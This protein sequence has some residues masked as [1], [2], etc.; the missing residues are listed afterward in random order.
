MKAYLIT[1]DRSATTSLA[2]ELIRLGVDTETW[3]LSDR[4]YALDNPPP[5]GVFV[6]RAAPSGTLERSERERLRDLV[7]WLEGHR[8]M[9]TR[10]IN[11]SGVVAL[12]SGRVL[13]HTALRAAGIPVPRT[14]A[15]VADAEAV[16]RAAEEIGGPVVVMSARPGTAAVRFENARALERGLP[17]GEILLDGGT[18]LVREALGPAEVTRL[19]FVGGTLRR[20]WRWRAEEGAGEIGAPAVAEELNVADVPDDPLIDRYLVFLH[21]HGFG[22]GA[23]EF[24]TTAQ[25]RRLTLGVSGGAEPW[26]W[27]GLEPA[28]A[29]LVAFEARRAG[30]APRVPSRVRAAV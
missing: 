20:A 5:D 10:V 9:G 29:A 12:E 4:S 8:Q 3:A 23:I 25:G 13:Q 26:R 18:V 15:A 7:A 24:A 22:I 21:T 19:E 14:V 30:V 6:N 2:S 17:R 11:G 16:R 27:S 1:D 28:V